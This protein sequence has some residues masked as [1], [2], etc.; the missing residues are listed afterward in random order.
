M[1][2]TMRRKKRQAAWG[3]E[4]E[5]GLSSSTS[6]RQ[7]HD[8][9]SED[10]RPTNHREKE[11]GIPRKESSDAGDGEVNPKTEKDRW[12]NIIERSNIKVATLNIHSAVH[13]LLELKTIC[14]ADDVDVLTLTETFF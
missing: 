1:R 10:K 9:C 13:K 7:R 3:R 5:G 8:V 14:D 6:A 11:E 4:E 12:A 2:K